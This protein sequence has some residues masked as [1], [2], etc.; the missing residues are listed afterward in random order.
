MLLILSDAIHQFLVG[1]TVAF[2]EQDPD[3]EGAVN[4]LN[5]SKRLKCLVARIGSAHR[6]DNRKGLLLE[7]V[8]IG[9]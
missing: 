7:R 5:R 2:S 6:N 9:L 8:P 3:E 4:R 1:V